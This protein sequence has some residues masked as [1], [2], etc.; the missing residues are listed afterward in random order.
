MCLLFIGHH[1]AIHAPYKLLTI[2]TSQVLKYCWRT[3][4]RN[5]ERRVKNEELLNESEWDQSSNSIS[6]SG[7]SSEILLMTDP[8]HSHLAVPHFS[9][10]ILA[11]Q[12]REE[13]IGLKLKLYSMWNKEIIKYQK[14]NYVKKCVPKLNFSSTS[15]KVKVIQWYPMTGQEATGTN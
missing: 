4:W 7:V 3:R 2:T 14:E 10:Q 15:K 6:S 1:H 13:N 8:P 9:D 5:C 12:L 11:L